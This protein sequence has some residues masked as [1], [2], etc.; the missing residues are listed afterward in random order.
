M[1]QH[2]LEFPDAEKFLTFA[3]PINSAGYF[4]FFRVKF[5]DNL[6]FSLS[7]GYGAG[8][9]SVCTRFGSKERWAEDAMPGALKGRALREFIG[10]TGVKI[11]RGQIG[12]PAPLPTRLTAALGRLGIPEEDANTVNP[13]MNQRGNKDRPR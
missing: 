12:A 9:Y 5:T 7:S 1:F 2:V 10:V 6:R 3:P 13:R 8:T 11:R 4:L